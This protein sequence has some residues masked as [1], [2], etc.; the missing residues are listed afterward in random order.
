LVRHPPAA[1]RHDSA[2]DQSTNTQ[3][4]DTRVL[5]NS[6]G[7]VTETAQ[8]AKAAAS[9]GLCFAPGAAIGFADHDEDVY[10]GPVDKDTSLPTAATTA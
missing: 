7:S 9:A 8:R 4:R 10:V 1:G 3:Q 2:Q 6:T 5:G